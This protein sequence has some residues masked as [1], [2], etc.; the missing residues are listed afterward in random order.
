MKIQSM[1]YKEQVIARFCKLSERVMKDVY[2][3]EYPADCFCGE[4]KIPDE[5]FIFSENV[6]KFIE[7]AVNASIVDEQIFED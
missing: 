6:M 5:Y 3:Y 1:F 4:N 2:H 7:D